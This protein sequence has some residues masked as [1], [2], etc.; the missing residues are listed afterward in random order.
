[1]HRSPIFPKHRKHPALETPALFLAVPSFT[2][3][4]PARVVDFYRSSVIHR[5]RVSLILHL[6]FHSRELHP[7]E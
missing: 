3:C 7:L 5:T 4:P 6:R 2:I 1:M